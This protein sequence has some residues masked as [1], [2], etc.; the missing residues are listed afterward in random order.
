[1]LKPYL[2]SSSQGQRSVEAVLAVDDVQDFEVLEA[3]LAV[4]VVLGGCVLRFVL[5]L[6]LRLDPEITP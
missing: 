4:R 1:M 3:Q 5:V 6:L 2:S